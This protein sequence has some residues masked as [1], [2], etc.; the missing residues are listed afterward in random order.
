METD[1]LTRKIQLG[2]GNPKKELSYRFPIDEIA[3][4]PYVV[5]GPFLP[6]VE[7]KGNE[8]NTTVF[9][10]WV[11]AW[12]TFRGF[13]F[14][15][16]IHRGCYYIYKSASHLEYLVVK[17]YIVNGL[18]ERWR[19]LIEK[20]SVDVDKDFQA[21]KTAKHV[22]CFNNGNEVCVKCKTSP[23]EVSLYGMCF[24]CYEDYISD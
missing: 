16:L 14:T 11:I 17:N 23:V 5:H 10:E 7:F 12:Y 24:N 13:S 15:Y 6:W 22:K 20:A 18:G 21:I 8:V 3:E 2:W 1:S 19:C 9:S 4:L